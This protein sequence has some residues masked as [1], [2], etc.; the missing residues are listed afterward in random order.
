[1]KRGRG[2]KEGEK[3]KG[4][5]R[6]GMLGEKKKVCKMK[7]CLACYQKENIFFGPVQKLF[8]TRRKQ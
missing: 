2:K 8:L 1:M 5:E 6:D 4:T 3:G 7:W